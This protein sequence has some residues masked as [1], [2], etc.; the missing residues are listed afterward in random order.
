MPVSAGKGREKAR[1]SQQRNKATREEGARAHRRRAVYTVVAIA[2]A[3]SIAY[4]LYGGLSVPT[5]FSTFKSNFNSADSVAIYVNDTNPYYTYAV[6]CADAI[7]QE[8]VGPTSAHRN[9]STIKFFII[10]DNS[11]SCIYNPGII[12][13]ANSSYANATAEECLNYSRSMP[14]IFLRYSDVNSTIV[15]PN[16]LYI[17]GDAR[18]MTLCGI[19]YQIV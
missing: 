5:S 11:T 17:S 12:G 3:M 6:T 18:M 9:A 1:A 14:S 16:R 7:I 19:A 2:A 10:Y 13:S 4:V 8:L 15:T